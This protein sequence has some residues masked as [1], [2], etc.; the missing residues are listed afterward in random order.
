MSSESV[1]WPGW[2]MFPF[3]MPIL[4]L[5]ILVV[6]L[7]LLF[8]GRG[9]GPPRWPDS[10]RPSSTTGNSESAIEILGKRYAKGEIKR[11]EFEQMKNDLNQA[12]KS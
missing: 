7:Y 3:G 4:I 12:G 10:D 2:W 9:Y 6:L 8:G 5:V 11:E 1:W